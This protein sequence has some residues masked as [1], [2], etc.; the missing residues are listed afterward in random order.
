MMS[1]LLVATSLIA[2]LIA[3]LYFYVK[4]IYSYWKRRGVPYLKPTI[5]FGNFGPLVRKVRSIGQNIH[6]LY[7]ATREPFVGVY[8]ALRPALLIRDPKITKD[9]LIKDF[10]HFHNR[11]FLLDA[12]VDPLVA[13]L[14][15]SDQKW[16]EMRT[17]Q[18]SAFSSAK[19]KGMFSTIVDCARPLEDCLKELAQ[20]G[21]EIEARE[22]FAR[23]TT[24]VI[25]SV[26]FGLDI[27]CFKE[28]N[29]EFREKGS[30]LFRSNFRNTFRLAISFLCPFLTRLIGI[31]FVDKDVSEFMV[32]TVRQNL[33]YR[34]KNHVV[35]KDYFQ[36][37]MQVRNGGKVHD[38]NWS[39]NSTS[40]EKFLSINDL[41][42][43]SFGLILAGYESS[44]VSEF[45]DY[46]HAY[47]YD[48]N[49]SFVVLS[50]YHGI[51][52]V[53]NGQKSSNS[54]TCLQRNPRGAATF[55]R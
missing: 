20:T 25:A 7:Y 34:E 33:E 22:I 49:G 30:R 27:D 51:F 2:I 53:R 9:I 4:H 19:L 39:A 13:N 35:R 54:T 21:D 10:Q 36:L 55:R 41:A 12:N 14:F 6:D 50:G 31:R 3:T 23:F 15:T 44:S 28:P 16:K 42:A 1:S 47:I 26:G 43:H 5:P 45:D 46:F 24:N 17:K 11:G 29:N 8:L 52:H 37:L 18:S 32:D 48:S 38:D 40:T